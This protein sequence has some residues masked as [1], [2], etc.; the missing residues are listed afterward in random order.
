MD[1]KEAL[2]AANEFLDAKIEFGEEWL[3]KA[4][5]LLP[6]CEDGTENLY[7]T[8]ARIIKEELDEKTKLIAELKET[9]NTAESFLGSYEVPSW[10]AEDIKKLLK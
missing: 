7:R 3:E 5:V 4:N 9:L 1:N 8:A 2:K 6:F 10:L